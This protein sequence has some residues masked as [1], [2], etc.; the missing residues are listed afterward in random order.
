MQD[1]EIGIIEILEH[2]NPALC[3]YQEWVNVGM[4]LKEEGYTVS[5]W[6]EW[7]KNDCRYHNGE[8]ERKW[9]TFQGN[10]NPVTAGTIF[11]IAKDQGWNPSFEGSELDWDSEIGKDRVIDKSW[12]E[13]R[14]LNIPEHWNPV[15]QLITYLETLFDSKENVG[16]VT[17][18]WEKDGKYLP[19]K[20]NYDRTAGEL[21]QA[22][23]NC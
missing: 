18:T 5:V 4:A 6:D 1:G 13:S 11:Q 22:L 3:S 20:G 7:S 16:Y 8:C 14:E 12:V 15:K 2:I 10:Q 17:T 9:K 23:N 19:T 21:I